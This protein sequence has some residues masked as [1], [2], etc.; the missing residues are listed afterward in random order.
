[1]EYFL[2]AV[3]FWVVVDFTTAFNPNLRDWVHHMPLIWLFYTT[4]PALFAFLIFKRQWSGARLFAAMIL[5]A[6]LVEVV[7]SKNT[8]LTTFP[9]LV[10][11]I[12]VAL[13]IYALITY[14]PKWIVEGKVRENK[15]VTITVAAVWLIVA[16]LSY[17]TRVGG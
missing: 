13:A 11:M 15:V 2:L 16:V 9:V 6:F 4:Y 14:V 10:I 8:L 7:I 3:L 1:L 5:M 12:P 17:K